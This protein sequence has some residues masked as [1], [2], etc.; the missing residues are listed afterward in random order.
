ME[1]KGRPATKPPT[2]KE[3]YYLEVRSKGSST[4]VKIRRDTKAE[5]EFAVRQ[6]EK[7]KTVTYLGE[8][9][10]GRWVD[11]KNAGKKTN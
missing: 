3:G 4:G 11:G 9:R 1:K 5:M 7:S 2:L 6:Y 8:V 10:A